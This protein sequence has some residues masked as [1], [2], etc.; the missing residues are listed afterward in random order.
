MELFG[1]G[2]VASLSVVAYL[3][4]IAVKSLPFISSQYVSLICGLVGGCFGLL[5]YFYHM[6][7]FPVSDPISAFAV[8]IVSGLAVVNLNLSSLKKTVLEDV[9]LSEPLAT[10]TDLLP[11]NPE[12]TQ[13]EGITLINP[14][15][16]SIDTPISEETPSQPVAQI[17]LEIPLQSL[18]PETLELLQQLEQGELPTP[19]S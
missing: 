12:P 10:I 7:N 9:A 3:A 1:I 6:D 18:N 16:S 14:E 8:G 13:K 2:A 5:S 19:P 4:K 17:P 11:D 15:I